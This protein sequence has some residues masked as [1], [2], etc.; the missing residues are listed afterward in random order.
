M[1]RA[2]VNWCFS[3]C[4][5]SEFKAD[6]MLFYLQ[7]KA[8]VGLVSNDSDLKVAVGVQNCGISKGQVSDLVQCITGVGNQLTKKDLFV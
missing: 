7:D 5:V 4:P 2:E 1:M 3:S 6:E 8:F